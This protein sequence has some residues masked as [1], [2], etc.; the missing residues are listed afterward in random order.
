MRLLFLFA[1]TVSA[2]AAAAP[3]SAQIAGRH[4]YGDVRLPD[5]FVGDGRLGGPG[6]RRDLGDVRD[7]IDDG[8]DSGDLSR[9]EARRFDREARLIGRLA[10]RYGRDGLSPAEAQELQARAHYLRDAVQNARIRSERRR[11]R[12]GG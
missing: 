10:Y 3:A 11:G 4:D 7:R 5:R 8:R 6:L 1:A 12:R 2:A 9:R